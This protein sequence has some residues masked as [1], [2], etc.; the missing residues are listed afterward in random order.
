VF[1]SINSGP[2]VRQNIIVV[3]RQVNRE[4]QFG[5]ERVKN[6]QK[7]VIKVP[8]RTCPLQETFGWEHP[9]NLLFVVNP[10]TATSY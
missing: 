7:N 9:W 5:Q 10:E 6:D 3:L 1:I 8:T 2:V 4:V